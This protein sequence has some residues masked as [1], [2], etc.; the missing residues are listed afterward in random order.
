MSLDSVDKHF[1][2]DVQGL[3]RLKLGAKNNSEE[4]LKEASQQFEAL[5]FQSMLKSMRAA[6][7]KSDLLG[8]SQ[9]EFYESMLDQQW[10]QELAGRGIGL[11]DQ[12][13]ASLSSQ[14]QLA[15]KINEASALANI[16]RVAP[17]NLQGFE[18]RVHSVPSTS[19]VPKND[20]ALKN[21][22]LSAPEEASSSHPHPPSISANTPGPAVKNESSEFFRRLAPSATKAS[23]ATGVPAELIL[24]QAALETGWGKH[25][26]TTPEGDNSFNLF[27]I[28]AGDNWQGRTTAVTT[29][30]YVNGVR[31]E[32]IGKF[33][34]YDSYEQS[35]TDYAT[36]L[37][38]NARYKDVLTADNAEQAAWALQEGG[39][40]TDPRYAEKLIAVINQ[41]RGGLTSG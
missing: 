13:V 11:A 3:S 2:L 14:K 16:P 22:P 23:R 39:Y 32:V 8:S 34:V 7:P 20:M 9:T 10:S 5:F 35:F 28:K 18:T 37:G 40:A 31:T 33:R 25:K 27:G 17:K 21:N 41:G 26:I 30:E 36:L 12:L 15:A 38:N 19:A 4:A 1:A 29:H 6:I 24:A